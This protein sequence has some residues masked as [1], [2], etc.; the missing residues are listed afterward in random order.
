MKIP[1][2]GKLLRI[3]IGESDRYE[4][5]P[6]YEAIVH[7][8]KKEGLAGCTVLRGIEGFGASSRIHTA[9]ILRLSA[10][11]PIVIEIVDAEEKIDKFCEQIDTMIQEGLV[12]VEKTTVLLYR[13]QKK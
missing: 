8:A 11:L 6:L 3:F 13:Y 9:K 4:G 10:D 5:K 2:D 12:T 1:E 7:R